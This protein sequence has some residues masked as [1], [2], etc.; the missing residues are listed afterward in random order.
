MILWDSDQIS[1]YLR[2]KRRTWVDKVSK[3]PDVPRPAQNWSQ[4]SRLWHRNE[5]LD[6]AEGRFKEGR[7]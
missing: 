7:R 6:W 5:I 2:I 1:A 3:R 4:K